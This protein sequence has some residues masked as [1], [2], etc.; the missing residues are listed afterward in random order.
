MILAIKIYF[1][2]YYVAMYKPTSDNKY[3]TLTV[4]HG[5]IAGVVYMLE[6]KNMGFIAEIFIRENP[7]V[8]EVVQWARRSVLWFA[9]VQPLTDQ[10]VASVNSAIQR[11]LGK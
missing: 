10:E 1:V 4:E 8:S 6:Q 2:I 11:L 7:D 9:P 5:D 3:L